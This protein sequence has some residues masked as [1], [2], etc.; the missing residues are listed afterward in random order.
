MFSFASI[1]FLS[2]EQAGRNLASRV[3]DRRHE[4]LQAGFIYCKDECAFS[5]RNLHRRPLRALLRNSRPEKRD[6]LKTR[7]VKP[8]RGFRDA[9]GAFI[10][11]R[12]RCM[13]H[14]FG[15]KTGNLTQPC[16]P[17]CGAYWTEYT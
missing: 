14:I 8:E 17:P 7:T 9:R 13:A 3:P 2:V 4:M 5:Q 16:M 15:A 12:G 6:P 1:T 10:R 11:A